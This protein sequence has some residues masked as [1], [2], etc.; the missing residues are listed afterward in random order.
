VRVVNFLIVAAVAAGIGIGAYLVGHAVAEP[1]K[2]LETVVSTPARA[3]SATAE[4]NLA[5]AVS[6]AASYKVDH[7]T[8]AGMSAS[9]LRSYDSAIVS[10][11]SV[12]KATHTA[13]CVE[14]TV[15]GATVSIVGPN[16]TFARRGC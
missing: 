10:D 8:Y 2:Q 16:G 9:D 13:Y 5:A 15:R 3:A 7:G 12:K 1:A 11:V 14:S 4:A 6:A